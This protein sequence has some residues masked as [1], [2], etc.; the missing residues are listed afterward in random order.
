MSPQVP[1]G[2]M[3]TAMY[4][5]TPT[6]ASTAELM[7]QLSLQ[8]DQHYQ[9]L[10]TS[11]SLNAPMVAPTPSAPEAATQQQKP[12][13]IAQEAEEEDFDLPPPPPPEEIETAKETNQTALP[14]PRPQEPTVVS[15]SEKDEQEKA[16]DTPTTLT[17]PPAPPVPPP[18]P[19]ASVPPPPPP[20]PPPPATPTQAKVEPPTL[21][22]TGP[23]DSLELP[24]EPKTP[25]SLQSDIENGLKK[26]KPVEKDGEKAPKNEDKSSALLAAI[27]SRFPSIHGDDDESDENDNNNDDWD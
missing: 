11:P 21:E 17:T 13:E 26:L 18:P 8:G 20:P 25:S 7:T 16:P 14:T 10:P 15:T 27:E 6:P 4:P 24:A 2:V 12:I 1:M 5:T 22:I 19:P 3:T 9:H 23:K